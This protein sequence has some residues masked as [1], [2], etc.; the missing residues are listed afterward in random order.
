MQKS[1]HYKC[2]EQQAYKGFFEK[3]PTRNHIEAYRISMADI[4]ILCERLYNDIPR[5]QCSPASGEQCGKVTPAVHIPAVKVRKM[6]ALILWRQVIC[7]LSMWKREKRCRKL[8]SLQSCLRCPLLQNDSW[9][10]SKITI[11]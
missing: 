6:H 2:E 1:S 3:I 8:W 4:K 9:P 7:N 10:Q 5:P 11:M